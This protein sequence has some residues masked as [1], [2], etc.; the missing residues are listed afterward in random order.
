MVTP[1]KE[2]NGRLAK[3]LRLGMGAFWMTEQGVRRAVREVRLPK[4]AT[5]FLVEQVERRKEEVFE[6]VRGE[7]ERAI[8]RVDIKQLAREL[9]EGHEIEVTA[10]VRFKPRK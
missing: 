9:L 3:L 2:P 10:T 6:V 7:I 8:D 5:Q 1:K 4:E